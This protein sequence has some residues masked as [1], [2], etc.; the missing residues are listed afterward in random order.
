MRE[1]SEWER[2]RAAWH[3]TPREQGPTA[4]F[5]K[6][7]PTPTSRAGDTSQ[8][9]SSNRSRLVFVFVP[10]T[11]LGVVYKSALHK[12]VR[13]LD[14]GH[15]GSSTRMGKEQQG[16]PGFPTLCSERFPL[17]QAVD[18]MERCACVGSAVVSL[19]LPPL[20]RLS[21]SVVQR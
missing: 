13:K 21:L 9:W 1:R 18:V 4:K 7:S 11:N 17:D 2:H 10:N 8:P 5:A 20:L 14:A 12:C 6:Q 19:S 15:E 3:A 16:S